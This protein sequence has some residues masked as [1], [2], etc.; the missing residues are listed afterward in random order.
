MLNQFLTPQAAKLIQ[1]YVS[2]TW[3]AFLGTALL[4]GGIGK[5]KG[6]EIPTNNYC[7]IHHPSLLVQKE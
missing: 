5:K 7:R 4:G 6:Y 3:A 2:R 1:K